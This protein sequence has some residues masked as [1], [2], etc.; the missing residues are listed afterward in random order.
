[1]SKRPA[2]GQLDSEMPLRQYFLFVG[3]ALL[4]LLLAANWR[5][6]RPLQTSLPIPVL[7]FRPSE[8]IPN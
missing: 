1:M 3:G 6:L 8:S 5:C 4:T 2:Q 7:G